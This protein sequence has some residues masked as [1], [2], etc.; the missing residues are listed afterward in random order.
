MKANI[1]NAVAE[2]R[3]VL[4]QVHARVPNTTTSLAGYPLLLSRTQA[5]STLVSAS[6]RVILND[7]AVY[8]ESKQ[9]ELSM[10]ASHVR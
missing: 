9:R 6:Q 4:E 7:V 2:I 5:C 1:D 10:S 3:T 8:F